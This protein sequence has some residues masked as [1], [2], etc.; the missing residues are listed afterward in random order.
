MPALRTDDPALL[1]RPELVTD[2]GPSLAALSSSRILLT[3]AG[4]SLGTLLATA[5]VGVP[6]VHLSLLDHHEHSLFSL[7]RLL[8][9]AGGSC[10]FVLADVRDVPRMQRVLKHERPDTVIHF[11]AYKHVHY[12][13]LFPE[14]AVGVNVQI[15][16]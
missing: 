7:Q 5:L 6:G 2:L 14:E 4:G 13:E 8:A 9:S 3:G 11:A 16:R 15:G 1:G 10:S 12:G